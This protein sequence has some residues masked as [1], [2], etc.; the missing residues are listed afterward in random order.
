MAW[1]FLFLHQLV[2]EI[3]AIEYPNEC[4]MTGKRAQQ[5][6]IQVN[7]DLCTLS[8]AKFQD[9][10]TKDQLKNYKVRWLEF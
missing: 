9:E 1:L 7:Q 2:Y 3:T 6:K 5:I 8:R 4:G 10:I